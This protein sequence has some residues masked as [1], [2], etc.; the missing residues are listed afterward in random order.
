ML[1]L[2]T[3]KGAVMKKSTRITAI[4]AAGALAVGTGAAAIAIADPGDGH[5]GMGQGS[6]AQMGAGHGQSM[7]GKGHGQGS[8]RGM[9]AGRG[10]QGFGMDA[11]TLPAQ[12]ST[13]PLRA[14]EAAAL[15]YLREEEKLARDVYT[16]LAR[17]SGDPRFTRIAASEQRHMDALGKLLTRYGIADPTA[18]KAAGEFESAKLQQLYTDLVAKGSASPAAALEVGR[19]IEKLDITDLQQRESDSKHSDVTTVFQQLERGSNMHLRAFTR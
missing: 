19:S 2:Q 8:G 14:S 16:T 5:G 7:D 3:L 15:T 12:K 6:G 11:A 13:A 9:N 10:G 18:G 17:T 1:L 4:V